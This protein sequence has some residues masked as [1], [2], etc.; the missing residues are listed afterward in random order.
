MSAQ[1]GI[2]TSSSLSP[3]IGVDLDLT[4]Q[5]PTASPSSAADPSRIVFLDPD[6]V[7]PSTSLSNRHSSAFETDSFIELQESIKRR[8]G[9]EEPIKVQQVPSADTNAQARYEI[10]FGHRRWEACRR[11]GIQV[12]AVIVPAMPDAEVLLERVAENAG[13]SDFS[14]YEFGRICVQLMD[15]GRFINQRQVAIELAKNEGLV[16]K[17]IQLANLPDDIIAAFPSPGDIAYRQIK[18]LHDTYED[19]PEAMLSAAIELKEHAD[20]TATEVFKRLTSAGKEPSLERFKPDTTERRLVVRGKAVG[21]LKMDAKRR[22][23]LAFS[24]S[25][26]DAELDALERAIVAMLSD[27]SGGRR[28]QRTET[29]Q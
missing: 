14:A 9:N 15:T 20:R 29:P 23:A 16:S 8:G 17:A 4:S 28:A 24:R 11:L 18:P 1:Q 2:A 3:T 19:A 21:T 13:R 12:R 25:F 6:S 27:A 7:R 26:D 5:P 10:V 22:P